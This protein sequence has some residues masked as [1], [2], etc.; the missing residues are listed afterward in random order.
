MPLYELP[1]VSVRLRLAEAEP[2]YSTEPIAT[3]EDAV[4]VVATALAEMDR[5]Y[6][7]VCNLDTKNRPINFNTVSIGDIDSAFI[8]VRN[9]FKSAILS[10]ATKIMVVHNHPSGVTGVSSE[11]MGATR[12]LIEAGNLIEIPLLDHVVVGGGSSE[13]FSFREKYPDMFR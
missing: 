6:V 10:N 9:V 11:D 8:S 1:Q 13:C 2:L 7:I 12:K 4:R 3:P 5:E